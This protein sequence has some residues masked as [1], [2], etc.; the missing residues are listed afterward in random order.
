MATSSLTLAA[1]A[2]TAVAG[3]DATSVSPYSSGTSGEYES[4][5]IAREDGKRYLA[6]LPLDD[7][8]EHALIDELKPLSAL[9]AGIRARFPF[10]VPLE[11][12][13][14][15]AGARRLYVYSFV[16]G[17]P[18]NVNRLR[19]LDGLTESV[20]AG[21][22]AIHGLPRG[23]V[24]DYGLPHLTAEDERADARGIARRAAETRRLPP[25]LASR[26]AEAFDADPLWEFEPLVVHGDLD[27]RSLLVNRDRLTAVL[28]WGRLRIGDPAADFGW[29]VHSARQAVVDTALNA[30]ERV[31]DTPVDPHL[32]QRAML[33]AEI[34]LAKWLLFGIEAHDDEV[35]ADATRMLANLNEVLSNGLMNPLV[36]AAR[37]AEPAGPV[38]DAAAEGDLADIG[39]AATDAEPASPAEAEE[40]PATPASP[41][42]TESAP[43]TPTAAETGV[44]TQP[45]AASEPETGPIPTADADA[46]AATEASAS[47]SAEVADED[48]DADTAETAPASGTAA[49]AEPHPA[50]AE[51][52]HPADSAPAHDADAPESPADPS[53]AGPDPAPDRAAADRTPA[54]T[55]S[56]SS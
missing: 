38:E 18:L 4:V 47:A 23:F 30:Y 16:A 42:E 8:A 55:D 41:A 45:S 33:H 19:P 12:G 51:S 6:R 25:L 21:I 14:V 54:H 50:A 49:T 29:L 27:E 26:W 44:G 1:L 3:L 53:T 28:S 20:A 35:I 7:D 32:R 31:V 46:A 36:E 22:A 11:A 17:Q 2:T 37:G 34:A 39:A 9:S 43:E 13:R 15:P 48:H 52:P 10:D 40:P 5:L 56:S 24:D